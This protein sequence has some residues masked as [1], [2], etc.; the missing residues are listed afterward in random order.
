MRF[1]LYPLALLLATA[2][3]V[4]AVESGTFLCKGVIGQNPFR[5]DFNRGDGFEGTYSVTPEAGSNPA[6]SG[7]G[8][9]SLLDGGTSIEIVDGPLADTLQ[10]RYIHVA[11]DTT[12][13]LDGPSS[14][15]YYC[16]RTKR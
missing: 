1:T 3:P 6:I 14:W 16:E 15:P 8:R 9:H 2:A 11:S 12:L 7:S 4:A 13:T 10:A 5:L